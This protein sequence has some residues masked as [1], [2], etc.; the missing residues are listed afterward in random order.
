MAKVQKIK[1]SDGREVNA[2]DVDF[3]THREEWNE[4]RTYWT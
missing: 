3:E 1:L 4:Y 2:V